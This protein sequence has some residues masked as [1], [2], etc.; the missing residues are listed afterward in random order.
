MTPTAQK[1]EDQDRSILDSNNNRPN[2]P[3][4]MQ[5]VNVFPPHGYLLNPAPPSASPRKPRPRHTMA[6]ALEHVKAKELAREAAE[7][8]AVAESSGSQTEQAISNHEQSAPGPD[9]RTSHQRESASSVDQISDEVQN[10]M[11][12]IDGHDVG[13]SEDAGRQPMEDGRLA[14]TLSKEDTRKDG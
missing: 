5:Y 8:A 9:D 11:E 13:V 7:A 1:D 14:D 6:E 4:S 12:N 2:E 3:E 10:L